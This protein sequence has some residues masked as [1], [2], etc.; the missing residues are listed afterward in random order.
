MRLPH[1][2]FSVLNNLLERYEQETITQ[3]TSDRTAVLDA[4]HDG[5]E[6]EYCIHEMDVVDRLHSKKVRSVG[7]WVLDRTVAKGG[8]GVVSLAFDC[9]DPNR[10]VAV[11]VPHPTW[12]YTMDRDELDAEAWFLQ[13]LDHPNIV[14]FIEVGYEDTWYLVTEWVNGFNLEEAIHEI[15][16]PLWHWLS[17][18]QQVCDALEFGHRKGIIHRDITPRNI[19]VTGE[20]EPLAKVLDYGV[21][22]QSRDA[23]TVTQHIKGTRSF[24]AP[25]QYDGRCDERSDVYSLGVVMLDILTK[26][27]GDHRRI[28]KPLRAIIRKAAAKNPENRYQSAAEFGQA[29]SEVSD[30]IRAGTT[31]IVHRPLR[32][33]RIASSAIMMF[34]ICVAIWFAL[35]NGDRHGEKLRNATIS[36]ESDSRVAIKPW[37]EFFTAE[38]HANIMI[39]SEPSGA[40]LTLFSLE[41]GEPDE[42]NRIELGTTP[43]RATVAPSDYLVVAEWPDGSWTEVLRRIPNAKTR[44]VVGIYP[45]ETFERDGDRLRIDS[46]VLPKFVPQGMVQTSTIM[47]DREPTAFPNEKFIRNRFCEALKSLE[48]QGK[49][50]PF[51]SEL[52]EGVSH[53]GLVRSDKEWTCTLVNQSSTE[54]I[55]KS[56]ELYYLQFGCFVVWSNA[57]DAQAMPEHLTFDSGIQFRGAR[58][59]QP[60]GG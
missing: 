20:G 36:S 39:D 35:T 58:S 12:H 28:A 26:W 22:K 38:G 43:V 40:Q 34:L 33:W 55:K 3:R 57:G 9:E 8:F 11:K 4:C 52:V 25:E 10:V 21:A 31:P 53:E 23:A 32:T 7:R 44:G 51:Q 1:E 50:L 41:A 37:S 17:V 14:T 5:S 47:I 59:L 16:A 18:F 6:I 29:I 46:V 42:N 49:R 45:F 24:I 19:M 27:Y 54:G 2:R 48:S 60:F 13:D 56:G 15:K 30:R